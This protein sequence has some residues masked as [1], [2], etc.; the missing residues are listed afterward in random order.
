VVYD[1][2][3]CPPRVRVN[4]PSSSRTSRRAWSFQSPSVPRSPFRW[5]EHWWL[6][7]AGS[8]HLLSGRLAE[9]L[10]GSYALSIN[11]SSIS[12]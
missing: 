8:S 5:I 7:H 1:R 6:A 10:F 4:V 2:E 11:Q 9:H 3:L 12:W